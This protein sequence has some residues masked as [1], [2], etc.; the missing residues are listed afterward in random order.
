MDCKKSYFQLDPSIT[1]INGAYMSPLLKSVE[2]VGIEGI[3]R[4]RNPV[5]IPP[6][7]FFG[8]SDELRKSFGR[9]VNIQDYNRIAII[10]S[11][12]YGMANVANNLN[13]NPNDE[14]V[15]ADAQ[16][17]SNVY[18]W[19]VTAKRSDAKIVTVSPPKENK[20]RGEVW[21]QKILD[22]INPK[23][24]LVALG[25][26]HW[27]D[28]TLFDLE[29]IREKT[30]KVGALL[31]ID[32]TQSIGA[33]PFDIHKFKPDALIV[34]GYKWMMGPYSLGLAYYGE[35]FDNGNPIE[36]NWINRENSEDFSNLV[37]Y[38]PNY[39]EKAIRYEVGEHSNFILV[40]ML[41]ESI[42]TLNSW[43]IDNIQE[44]CRKL[45]QKPIAEFRK[46]GFWVE[47]E[48]RRASHLFGLRLGENQ[49]MDDIKQR[50]TAANISVS[51]RGD[52]IRIS[53][54]VYNDEQD[55]EKMIEA[56]Q[57]DKRQ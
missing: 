8:E 6:E 35:A 38:N 10:P 46:L 31:V 52:S 19:H 12:S 41:M 17:P 48:S 51:F 36:E 1:F 27:A 11:V 47:E 50:L 5:H 14:I 40:P 53:P 3:L 43:G 57:I 9:L 21:N 29:A 32:G 7:T 44:Y 45:T 26:I 42:N 28:G 22:A 23:T 25:H 34:A 16:F 20:N 37:N 33:L 55:F 49:N 56:L 39:K 30:Y 18:S 2:Q 15:L 24:R 13:L 54:H 4:K